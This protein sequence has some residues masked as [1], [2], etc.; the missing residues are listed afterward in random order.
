VQEVKPASELS[1]CFGR[2]K[3]SCQVIKLQV[4]SASYSLRPEKNNLVLDVTH[5]NT[6][7]LDIPL[8]RFIVLE[9]VTFSTR[10]VFF[11]TEGVYSTGESVFMNA[12]HFTTITSYRR[13]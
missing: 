1:E 5:P 11:K 4:V 3:Y 6:T 2:I 10:F 13:V 8:S 7:N 9:Y 12:V